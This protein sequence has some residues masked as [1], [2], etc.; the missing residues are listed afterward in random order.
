MSRQRLIIL[1]LLVA[2]FALLAVAMVH[3]RIRFNRTNFR[4]GSV[5]MEIVN[6]IV[7]KDIPLSAMRPPAIR[8]SD[9]LRFGNATSIVSV[10]EYGD[11]RCEGCKAM[12][13]VVMRVA[14]RYDGKVRVV[15]RDLIAEDA[16]PDAMPAAVFA[17]CAGLQGRFWDTHDRLMSA[18]SLG[19]RTYDAVAKDLGL[20]RKLLDACRALPEVEAAIRQDMNEA[21]GDGIKSVPFFFVG[22][23]AFEGAIDEDAL[24][25]AIEQALNS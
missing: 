3:S 15:W 14:S 5:P 16:H 6:Q 21:M 4:V 13:A 12:D 25:A 7:P 17:R 11:Y 18:A 2:A 22:T 24:K 20:D 1:A 9:H 23:Q 10:I 19:N 8:A